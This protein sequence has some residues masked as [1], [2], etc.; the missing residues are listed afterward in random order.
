MDEE[1]KRLFDKYLGLADA[2]IDYGKLSEDN[3]VQKLID[4]WHKY[5]TPE[6]EGLAKLV[7]GHHRS[8]LSTEVIRLL[9]DRTNFS[10]L[11]G[12]DKRIEVEKFVD[13]MARFAIKKYYTHR[14]GEAKADEILAAAKSD[15]DLFETLTNKVFEAIVDRQT[16]QRGRTAMINILESQYSDPESNLR[17]FM[18][19]DTPAWQSMYVGIAARLD[20]I[21]QMSGKL[22]EEL[23]EA[24]RRD[25]VHAHA[26]RETGL[27][28]KGDVRGAT[29]LEDTK[30]HMRGKLDDKRLYVN[31]DIYE[32]L[33]ERLKDGYIPPKS[34]KIVD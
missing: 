24:Y 12:R 31:R 22:A 10:D 9:G 8:E 27:T 15:P 5:N 33:P 34:K 26:T 17:D 4:Q 20:P 19:E 23:N 16:G 3:D 11:T 2:E 28:Y 30:L 6:A 1:K 32:N 13:N 25:A 18:H 21:Q 7:L 29:M 14:D